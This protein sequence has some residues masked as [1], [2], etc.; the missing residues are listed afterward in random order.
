[1]TAHQLRGHPVTG[2]SRREL[3]QQFLQPGLPATALAASLHAA[4]EQLQQG[5]RP[6]KEQRLSGQSMAAGASAAGL[7]RLHVGS[8]PVQRHSSSAVPSMTSMLSMGS[9]LGQDGH[10]GKRQKTSD[11]ED[12][13]GSFSARQA[14]SARPVQA[15]AMDNGAPA[16]AGASGR[17]SPKPSTCYREGIHETAI[18]DRGQGSKQRGTSIAAEAL[19]MKETCLVCPNPTTSS[20]Q[21][22][23][24]QQRIQL[25]QRTAANMGGPAEP[26]AEFSSGA[27]P[28]AMISPQRMPHR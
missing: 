8:M 20:L 28:V 10:S 7:G 2:A 5:R 27:P 11:S 6:P 4:S 18:I 16:K 24:N 23:G 22:T 13:I 12:D 14:T 3:S 25:V 1:M 15:A 17:L 9:G 19:D 26:S 21:S